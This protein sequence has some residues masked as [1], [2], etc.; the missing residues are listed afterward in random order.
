MNWFVSLSLVSSATTTVLSVLGALGGVWLVVSKRRWYV[1]RALP[2]GA[3]AAFVIGVVL[4]YVVE[5]VWRPFPDP[6]ETEIYV[7]IGIGLA[8]VLL[9]VPRTIAARGVLAKAASVIAAVLV[10][11]AASAHVNLVFSAYPTVGTL[12]GVE[13]VDRISI[14]DIPGPQEQVVSG[15]PTSDA[16]QPPSSMPSAGKLTSVTIPPTASSFSARQAEI[17]LPPSYFAN[18]RPLLPVLVLL[19]GQPGEPD[20][21]LKGG[22]LAETMDAFARDHGGLA[23]VVVVADATGSTLANP[24]CVDSPLGNV[25]TYLSQDVPAWIKQ[26]LQVSTDPRSWII[27]GLSYGGTCSIQ[28]ATNH[29]DV[30]PTFLDLSGQVEPTLGDRTR[31]VD[32]AFGG[33]DAAFVAV[34]PLDLLKSEQFPNSGGAFVV[35]ADDNDYKPGQQTMYQAAKAAGMDVRY[36]EV[37]GGHSFAVWSQGLE[38]ELPW[39]MKRVGL[40]S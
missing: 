29:P 25:A 15:N 14:A 21:W 23:P 27:G 3:T 7:W 38:L 35:G 22:K 37:P 32:E 4:Y 19:A 5:K 28:M 9:V 40:I 18:P 26:N 36:D 11:L 8:A 10:V 31:T 13:D 2:I 33:N 12:F 20:D 24:L 6:I 16:W 17:Y 39:L 1:L 30:Y 34:N